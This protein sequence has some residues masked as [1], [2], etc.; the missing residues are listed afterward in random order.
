MKCE[1]KT[2]QE[3]R[4]TKVPWL[5]S[6]ADLIEYVSSLVERE[7]DYGTSAYAASLAAVAAFYYVSGK[8]GL[9]GF[10]ASCA[11]LDFLRKTRSL[12]GPFI[13]LKA[14]DMCYPQ[15]DLR[16]KLDNAMEGW[17]EWVVTKAKENLE[18]YPD[19]S[20]APFWKILIDQ[21][22]RR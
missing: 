4:E 1:A 5:N 17:R 8:L 20:V 6:E 9:T 7:H 22:G 11:D 16:E 2:E 21:E 18:A 3:M 19:V 12:D 14:E 15:Y 10:Q 13:I